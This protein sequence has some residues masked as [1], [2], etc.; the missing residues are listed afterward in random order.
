MLPGETRKERSL[1]SV[2]MA[3]DMT[4][5]HMEK[6]KN[7]D[8]K[9]EARHVSKLPGETQT[10]RSSDQVRTAEYMTASQTE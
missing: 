6:N 2:R 4:T 7:E 5:P 3:E 10:E 9:T 1:D 8:L